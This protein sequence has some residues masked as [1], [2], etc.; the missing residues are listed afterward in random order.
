MEQWFYVD[1]GVQRGPVDHARLAELA[2][3]LVLLKPTLVWKAGMVEWR[4]AGEV[5]AELFVATPK[6]LYV[7]EGGQ[8]GPVDTDVLVNL[9][10]AGEV[11]GG[12]LVWRDG[13]AEWQAASEVFPHV[14]TAPRI[15]PPGALPALKQRGFMGRIGARISDV[16]DL[17][18][19]SNVPI[20]DVLVGGLGEAATR[21]TV[22][23]EDAFEVGT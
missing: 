1:E 15:P 6:W 9:V 4:P 11:L 13:M 5:F 8:K 23:T 18:T 2:Q 22:D 10:K 14:F 16:A 20:S 21:R 19:I 7:G 3:T 17:P 12:T